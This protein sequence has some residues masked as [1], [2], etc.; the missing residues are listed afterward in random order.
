M[1]C[2]MVKRRQQGQC[3][4][5]EDGIS[6][7]LPNHGRSCALIGLDVVLQVQEAIERFQVID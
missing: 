2:L 3:N 4:R 6:S 5:R 1:K 7:K